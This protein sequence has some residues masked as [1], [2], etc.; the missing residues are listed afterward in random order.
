MFRIVLINLFFLIS[1]CI[2]KP[3]S[4]NRNISDDAFV[5]RK[6]ELNF[7]KV[8]KTLPNIMDVRDTVDLVV[9]GKL[10]IQ[11]VKN[12]NFYVYEKPGSRI[13]YKGSLLGVMTLPKNRIKVPVSGKE[14]DLYG[15][16]SNKFGERIE[17]KLDVLDSGEVIIRSEHFNIAAF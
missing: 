4:V 11:D 13:I 10:T 17:S 16:F 6:R 12:I 3:D 8:M 9:Y 1:G 14:Y 2:K 5:E 7:E 15:V